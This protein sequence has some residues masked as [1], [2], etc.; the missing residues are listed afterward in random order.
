MPQREQRLVS[1]KFD[2]KH[3]FTI[4]SFLDD[5]GF[6][7]YVVENSV[8]HERL[9]IR[10]YL[11]DSFRR[12]I[13]SLTER[14]EQQNNQAIDQKIKHG[15]ESHF[16][17]RSEEGEFSPLTIK[18]LDDAPGMAGYLILERS[19]LP[20][21]VDILFHAELRHP[22]DVL[23][24]MIAYHRLFQFTF[25]EASESLNSQLTLRSDVLSHIVPYQPHLAKRKAGLP[26]PP[27]EAA[28]MLDGAIK[29]G[30]LAFRSK[31]GAREENQQYQIDY[32]ALFDGSGSPSD[33]RIKSPK[34]SSKA[35]RKTNFFYL[36]ILSTE[37]KN[38][39]T[40]PFRCEFSV[41]E[42]NEL[43]E[44]FLGNRDED[45][46]VGFEICD[47][48]FRS[49][50]GI[51]QSFRFP[52]YYLRVSV[53]ESGRHLYIQPT[54]NGR[55]YLNHIAIAN[56]VQKFTKGSQSGDVLEKFFSTLLAQTISIEGDHG[57]VYLSRIL[58]HCQPVFEKV[59][60]I[61]IGFPGEKGKG[62]MLGN[63]DVLGIEVDLEATL[64][65]KSTAQR[66]ATHEALDID[67]N[68]I[69]RTAIDSP[70][71]FHGSLLGRFLLGD[72]HKSPQDPGFFNPA[73]I[74]GNINRSTRLLMGK[75]TDHDLVLL[76][77]PPGT[78]KT[79][80]IMNLFI[81]AICTG[82]KLLVVSDQDSGIHALIEKLREF[83]L[84]SNQRMVENNHLGDL[85]NASIK[86]IDRL[87][88]TTSSLSQW[89]SMLKEMLHL[90]TLKEFPMRTL[91]PNADLEGQVR[92]IDARIHQLKRRI[93]RI[94]ETRVGPDADIRKRVSYKEK[95]A[96]T[97]KDIESMVSFLR[98]LG[99]N[100][101]GGRDSE[102]TELVRYLLRRFIHDRESLVLRRLTPFVDLLALPK[103]VSD[104]ELAL[105]ARMIDL[106]RKA[107]SLRWGSLRRFEA[108]ALSDRDLKLTQVLLRVWQDH[109]SP[110]DRWIVRWF[111][112]LN[113]A[114]WSPPRRLCRDL[115]DIFVQ[116]KKIL[117]LAAIVEP[118][119]WQ[120]LRIMHKGLARIEEGDV[121]LS[122]EICRFAIESL[123]SDKSLTSSR[124]VQALLVEI[125][126]LL[127]KRS[128]IIHEKVFASLADIARATFEA[129]PETGT[130]ALT[131]LSVLIE[132]LKSYPNL[133]QAASVFEDLQHK[134]LKAFPI[135]ICRKQAVS[136]LFPC[137]DNIFD[138]VIVDEAT[139][140]RVDDALPLMFRAKKVMVVGDD[141]QTVL[142]KNSS[143][144]DYLFRE[145]NLAEHLRTSQAQGFK[146]GGSN[147]FGLVKGIKQGSVMLEEHYRCPPEIIEFSN[148]YVY[149]D[150][151]KIMQWKRKGQPGSLVV[152]FQEKGQ[153]DKKVA[154]GKFKGIETGMADRFLKFI[155]TTIPKIE[156]EIGHPINVETDVAICY[157]LLKNEPYFKAVKGDFLQRLGRGQEILDGAG[158]ALQGKE[159]D[160]IFYYW[161]VSRSNMMAFRQGD[162]E[163][164]RR[165]ELNV[166]M[167][168][169]K[170]R[171]YHYLH[172][173]FERLDHSRANIV[174]YLWKKFNQGEELAHRPFVERFQEPG[175]QFIA[176]R[177]SSGQ[178]MHGILSEA[179]KRVP[180]RPSLDAMHPQYSVV[181]GD[182][183]FKV[184]LMLSPH[185]DNP[186]S[187]SV[188]V[189]DLCA[190]EGSAQGTEDLVDYYFQVQ[191][192]Q[193]KIRPVF[194]F[195]HELATID[196]VAFKHLLRGLG[197][198]P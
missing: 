106:L 44:S 129:K 65:Y 103:T 115:I 29:K 72:G 3:R 90:G 150:Q 136:F 189:V 148:H 185:W 73:W 70:L 62:G 46:F 121:P 183:Q 191:R 68:N 195:M 96:T 170:R 131:T 33:G 19:S 39:S 171:A 85:W 194:L 57:R 184:D 127:R 193:P 9:P 36:P 118:G 95:H 64:L 13:K 54:E 17:I 101:K 159:R 8:R 12:V 144:D 164:K 16:Q 14:L 84:R 38:F 50:S 153:T 4:S 23:E 197:K 146:G 53:K 163:D 87:P 179:F 49:P 26:P 45:L 156:A 149:G 182:P 76:E 92:R 83:L 99:H 123:Y 130:N 31:L 165:G 125:K 120:Q 28:E 79:F 173:E 196:T 175:P 128:A 134:L 117:Q 168:R 42:V 63:L 2:R 18:S 132:S 56:L 20:T 143:M 137:A 97:V 21:L 109:F 113:T 52:L 124:S 81:H 114:W 192:A 176:W 147:L 41:E 135:W 94:M 71:K 140:C 107:A 66:S 186:N 11:L 25:A 91:A 58:P 133:E 181:V 61:L 86:V 100:R 75:V 167:S 88:A 35:D 80:T 177:R 105:M 190:F 60:E 77:G 122:L 47:A 187:P 32:D 22:S 1:I 30:H 188:G 37:I 51:M 162:E 74:P 67:L 59:R 126:R 198:K 157:F 15:V 112:I 180:Q 6:P 40:V 78:G 43:R 93:Q 119:V 10:R 5:Y 69:L 160:Y 7:F 110:S 82:K 89:A 154:T 27:K 139:Q 142:D 145:F 98:F 151:L 155:E 34:Q 174:E 169:P 48:I 111:K 161:D 138:M 172:R 104:T 152:N 108:I 141:R 24:R 55:Y 158:A 166:L 116:Q 102:Q 178:L